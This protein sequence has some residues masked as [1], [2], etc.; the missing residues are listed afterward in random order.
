MT[1]EEKE[2][3]KTSEF[4]KY[5]LSKDIKTKVP[6]QFTR[7]CKCNKLIEDEFIYWRKECGW[8]CEDCWDK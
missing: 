2:I 5:A 4:D 8:V 7:C 6:R 1:T 3:L